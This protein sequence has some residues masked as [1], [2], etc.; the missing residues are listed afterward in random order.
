MTIIRFIKIQM[1]QGLLGVQNAVVL[2]K[3]YNSPFVNKFIKTSSPGFESL[4]DGVPSN[5]VAKAY[6]FS[7]YESENESKQVY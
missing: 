7:T 1:V 6:I 5:S 2:F 4:T 3:G